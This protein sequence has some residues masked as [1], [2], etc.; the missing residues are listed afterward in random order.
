MNNN[1]I[2]FTD[3][4][5][6]GNPGKAGWGAVIIFDKKEVL[7]I[8][9]F[10]KKSTNNRMEMTSAIESFKTLEKNK[11]LNSRTQI[12]IY[13]DSSYVF[14]GITKWISGWVLRGWIGVNKNPV[15][16]KDLWEQLLVLNNKFKIEWKLLPGHSG[17][18]GNERAD[19]V[20]TSFASENSVVL[21]KGTIEKYKKNILDFKT[22]NTDDGR[23]K[24]KAYSYLSMIDGIIKKH[25]TWVECESRVKEKKNAKFRKSIDKNDEEKIINEWRN[26]NC[27]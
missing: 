4:S 10:E 17:I 16:N 15:L 26:E 25:E 7:E 5:A 18:V 9:G 11:V 8:G 2:I 13:T 20:A 1:I 21:Y 14:N 6:L 27:R 12:N 19:E 3:G 23:K 24:M 22:N